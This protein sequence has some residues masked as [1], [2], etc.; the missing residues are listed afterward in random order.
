MK[1]RL[2]TYA[3]LLLAL[4][5]GT[6]PVAAQEFKPKAVIHINRIDTSKY[7]RVRF[8]FA[9]L[10]SAGELVERSSGKHYRLVVDSLS[11][12]S[13]KTIKKFTET[14]ETMALVL[15]LMRLCVQ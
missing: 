10:D 11:K 12:G 6:P 7:P 13:F 8:F 9:E 1:R 2:L 14:S 3:S 5:A 4:L 15:V